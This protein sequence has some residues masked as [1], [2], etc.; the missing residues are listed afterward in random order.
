VSAWLAARNAQAVL[1]RPDHYVF[2][3]GAPA[4]LIEARATLLGLSLETIV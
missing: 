1:V 3:T 2:G 4:E